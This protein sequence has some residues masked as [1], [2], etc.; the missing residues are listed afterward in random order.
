[1]SPDVH[2][3]GWM[4]TSGRGGEGTDPIL[5]EANPVYFSIRFLQKRLASMPAQ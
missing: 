4:T 1:M 3:I 5:D 2:A